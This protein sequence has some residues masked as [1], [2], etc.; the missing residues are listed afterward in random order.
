MNTIEEEAGEDAIQ[1]T[2][3]IDLDDEAEHHDILLDS[4]GLDKSM[5]D[6]P[7]IP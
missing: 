4:H 7:P 1:E 6:A 5:V 3:E 2:V